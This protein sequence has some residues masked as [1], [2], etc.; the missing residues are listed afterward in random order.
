MRLQLRPPREWSPRHFGV[1]FHHGG[2]P[3]APVVGLLWFSPELPEDGAVDAGGRNLSPEEA[4]ARF[5]SPYL[6]WVLQ[7]VAAPLPGGRWIGSELSPIDALR[8]ATVILADL[9]APTF[10]YERSM[11]LLEPLFNGAPEFLL[12]L[13]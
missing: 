12:P 6:G 13:P 7:V 4:A 5:E 8:R 11:K 10:D 1:N 3:D 2:G 9:P